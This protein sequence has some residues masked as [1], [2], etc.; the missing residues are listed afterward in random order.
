MR[1]WPGPPGPTTPAGLARRADLRLSD[2]LDNVRRLQRKLWAAAK[3]SAR[4]RFHALFDR[5]YRDDV[6]AEAWKRVRANRGAAGVD[7]VTLARWRSYGVDRMLRRACRVTS[8]RGGIVRRR[9]AGGDPQA[10]WRQAAVGYPHR[11]RPGGP[12]GGEAGAGADLRGRLP[13]GVVW[14][15]AQAVGDPG[16]GA[17]R[18]GFIEGGR[19]VEFDIGTSSADRARPVAGA[20]RGAGVGSAGAQAA[21]AVAAGGCDGRRDGA[22]DGRGHPPGRGDLSALGQHLPERSSTRL[23]AARPGCPGPL[24]RRRRG[25]VPQRRAGRAALARS[26][27]SGPAWVW[28]STPT[29]PEW[30]TCV[31]AARAWTSWVAT[32][33]PG[34]RVGCWSARDPPPLPPSLAETTLDEA[35]PGEGQSPDRR[36]LS[37][38]DIREVIADLNPLLRGWENYFRTGNAAPKFRQLDSLRGASTPSPAGQA[39]G[40]NLHAGQVLAVERGLVQRARP[41]P[42]AWH[43]RLSV[44]RVTMPRRSSVSRMRENRT[45]GSKGEWGNRPARGTAPLTT[46]GAP[47]PAVAPQRRPAARRSR[48]SW[49]REPRR[50]GHGRQRALGQRAR[51]AAHRGAPRRARRRC[52]TSSRGC[53]RASASR[54]L[55]AYAFSTENWQRSPDEVRFLMGFNRDVIRRR[56]R[57]DA[58][59]WACGSGGPGGG[60]G[61]GAAVIKRA[62]DRRG[63]DPAQRRAHPDHVRQLRR[64]RRDRRR[65]AARSPR[66][67]AAGRLNPGKVDERMIARYLDEPDMPDVD[68]FI[69]PSGEQR[70]SNFLLWQTAYAEMV[71]QDRPVARLRPPRPLACL[72]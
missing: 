28:S 27:R 50:A 40:R 55:S 69:R 58:R 46:S 34:C 11:S 56:A 62:G 24:C 51:A 14:V 36:N 71:F 60:R 44:G 23:R 20:G 21:A 12:A 31:K 67:A 61:C 66:L 13:A 26:S 68:L 47:T 53:H 15:S 9:P 7:R 4:R 16:D 5:I 57:R 35:A 72:P 38:R 33:A 37:P 22:A 2:R 8:A 63:A 45:S 32:S 1:A 17:I 65:R 70:T 3:Q 41:A 19:V 30:L 10:R 6:L 48:A 25:A 54:W 18:V 49:C 42:T 52:W 39:R 43:R 59:R 64:P 29:R